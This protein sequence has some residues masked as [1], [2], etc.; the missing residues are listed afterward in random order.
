[1][2]FH[3]QDFKFA[4]PCVNLKQPIAVNNSSVNLFISVPP[5]VSSDGQNDDIQSKWDWPTVRAANPK[6]LSSSEVVKP[7]SATT[8]T[9]APTPEQS[10]WT[11]AGQN[12]LPPRGDITDLVNKGGPP[13]TSEEDERRGDGKS[14][15][16][17][18][19]NGFSDHKN[20]HDDAEEEMEIGG[21]LQERGGAVN[22]ERGEEEGEGRERN[23]QGSMSEDELRQSVG[24]VTSNEFNPN[25]FGGICEEEEEMAE[26]WSA[27]AGE[28]SVPADDSTLH[29]VQF[30]CVHVWVTNYAA[31]FFAQRLVFSQV[32]IYYTKVL[33]AEHCF[34]RY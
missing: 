19:S 9:V 34:N 3:N 27:G 23:S 32:L 31:N 13:I 1:M 15:S 10:S 6:S 24:S 14:E 7:V 12:H 30:V 29:Q 21:A 4:I 26:R 16:K 11:H 20:K 2:P 28:T 25:V 18:L 17:R 22:G 5:F 33:F 8:A